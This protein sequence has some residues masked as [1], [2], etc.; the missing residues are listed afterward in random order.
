[1]T[2]ENRREFIVSASDAPIRL[3]R[4]LANSAPQFSRSRIQR[5][6]R[7]GLIAVNGSVPRARDLVR[8]GDRIILL[9]PAVQPIDLLPEEIALAVLYEDADLIVLHKRAGM[10]VH[11]GDGRNRGTLVHELLAQCKN[12][13]GIGGKE[14]PGIVHRLDK[15]T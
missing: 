14:R 5:L 8:P 12:L 2:Q 15:D 10:S 9:E 6:I 3:D 7:D 1:M 11:P 13:S 4:F